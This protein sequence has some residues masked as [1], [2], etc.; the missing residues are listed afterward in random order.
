MIILGFVF[1]NWITFGASY[2]TSNFQW[3]FPIAVQSL[4]AIY[5]L[6]TVP[7][8]VESPRW[9]ANHKS[10]TE[11]ASVIARLRGLPEDHEEVIKVRDEIQMA[12]EEEAGGSWTDIFK[13]G[14][15]QNFRRMLLG[16]GALYM[17]QMTGINT[18]GYLLSC[19]LC[20]VRR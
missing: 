10:L 11:A 5:L 19:P 17:Q 6:V 15:Q 7:F 12:L 13:N 14:G 8:L 9:I 18:I 16:F 20:Q 3:T 4:F 2:A 1:S